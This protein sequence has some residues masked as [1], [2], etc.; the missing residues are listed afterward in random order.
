MKG[1]A[2]FT[3]FSRQFTASAAK[4]IICCQ[5]GWYVPYS[6]HSNTATA[7]FGNIRLLVSLPCRKSAQQKLPWD[8]SLSYITENGQDRLVG[9][10]LLA[11]IDGKG[12]TFTLPT[13]RAMYLP[14]STT[15]LLCTCLGQIVY[16]APL[17]GGA[18]VI[19]G[20]E[21]D[22]QRVATVGACLTARAQVQRVPICSNHRNSGAA[23]R[24]LHAQLDCRWR[25]VNMWQASCHHIRQ[26]KT[27]PSI[28][29]GME[30]W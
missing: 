9:S 23:K 15:P 20:A 7:T 24:R 18:N 25:R 10:T 2:A 6:L 27:S 8:T 11:V 16:R 30:N 28:L 4:P 14:R 3:A 29:S 26:A 12:Q 22:L 21:A 17:R 1:F 5:L 19:S 13:T